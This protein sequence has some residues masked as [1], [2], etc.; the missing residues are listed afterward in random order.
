[1]DKQEKKPKKQLMEEQLERLA[2]ARVKAN[3]VRKEKVGRFSR[4]YL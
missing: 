3:A 1:M 2:T 4:F